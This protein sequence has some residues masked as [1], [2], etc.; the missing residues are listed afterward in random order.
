MSTPS[1]GNQ[2]RRRI[3]GERRRPEPA[4]IATVDDDEPAPDPVVVRT[5]P[6]QRRQ[7]PVFTGAVALAFVLVAAAL[8][9]G[10]QTWS[11][12]DVRRHDRVEKAELGASAAAERAAGAILS[13]KHTSLDADLEKATTYMTSDF[14]KTYTGSFD[15]LARPNATRTKATVTA[16]VLATAVVTASDS[17]AEILVYV[18]QTTLSTANGG[19][20]SVA[21]NRTTFDL[22]KQGDRWLVDDFSAY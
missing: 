21:L 13:F 16:K 5:R 19:D 7:W 6:S 20:P 17:H 11:Y 22:V 12:P 15:S 1:P 4:D 2:R 10:L 14:A 8:W 3:A 9:L 18:D